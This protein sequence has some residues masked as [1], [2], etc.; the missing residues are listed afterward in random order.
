MEHFEKT[1]LDTSHLKPTCWYRYIDDTFVIWPHGESTLTEFLHHLNS[2]H[3]KIQFTMEKEHD[4]QISF[5]DV[6]VT[7]KTD[8]SLGHRVYRKPTLT[9]R[10]LNKKSN[11]HPRQKTGLIKTLFTRA[12]RISEESHLNT[13]KQH[14]TQALINNGYSHSDIKRATR[15]NTSTTNRTDN[16]KYT[17]KAFLP[18]IKQVTDRIG[19][20]LE[21]NNIQPI[22]TPTTKIKQTHITA[23]DK[24]DP[25]SAAGVYKIP[26]SCGLAYIGTTKRSL[27]TRISE[28]RRNCRLA[29]TDKSA[30]A[31]HGLQDGHDIDF[32]ETQ[33][34]ANTRHYHARLNR[35][36]IEIYKHP[37]FN[38]KEEGLKLNKIW[39]SVIDIKQSTQD[40]RDSLTPDDT[41]PHSTTAADRDGINGGDARREPSFAHDS[42]P[43]QDRPP[44]TRTNNTACADAKEDVSHRPQPLRKWNVGHKTPT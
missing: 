40:R 33:L 44:A 24:R 9:D 37:N 2:I 22:Y 6:A 12:E 32:T 17:G 20:L 35:E 16:Q 29:Q 18:Y 21:K 4:G 28:H 8:G 39:T 36:A 3:H 34:L 25:L 42:P 13:E 31:E 11:H 38:R 1:A 15:K 10:Y 30:V 5:L 27:K 7:W 14:L 43:Q 23:K 41:P 26:C 19:K